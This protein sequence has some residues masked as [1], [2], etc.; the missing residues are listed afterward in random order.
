MART[1]RP[2][3]PTR[4]PSRGRGALAAALV[5]GGLLAGCATGPSVDAEVIGTPVPAGSSAGEDEATD[6][7]FGALGTGE[8]TDRGLGAACQAIEGIT[9]TNPGRAVDAPLVRAVDGQLPAMSPSLAD[10]ATVTVLGRWATPEDYAATVDDSQDGAEILEDGRAA[11]FQDGVEID[12]RNALE[13]GG[14]RL[15]QM[16]DAAAAGGYIVPHVARVCA[17]TT[18]A[19]VLPSGNGFVFQYADGAAMAIFLA[20]DVEVAAT[21]CVCA[22]NP[23]TFA[24][25]TDWAERITAYLSTPS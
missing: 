12:I 14:L 3:A 1:R 20:G 11:G 4:P 13:S 21:V 24:V 15:L 5:V 2:V 16:A 10:D 9:V 8:E 22:T 23:D 7:G 17:S 18:G 25:A 19:A 6:G